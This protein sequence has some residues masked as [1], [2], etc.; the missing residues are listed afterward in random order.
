MRITS[1][2]GPA[3]DPHEHVGNVMFCPPGMLRLR[4]VD[5]V[6][7]D[8]EMTEWEHALWCV[9]RDMLSKEGWH[10][11]EIVDLWQEVRVALKDVLTC[12]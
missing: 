1:E 10:H 6:D 3:D 9:L 12:Y 2:T 8:D 5:G 4:D 11:S 7:P